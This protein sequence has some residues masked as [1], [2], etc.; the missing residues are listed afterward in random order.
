MRSGQTKPAR[1][2]EE[3]RQEPQNQ[4]RARAWNAIEGE[5]K[6]IEH[7]EGAPLESSTVK[8][9]IGATVVGEVRRR[10]SL[11][12][13]PNPTQLR[14]YFIGNFLPFLAFG[15]FD[16]TIMLICGE[17]LHRH[18]GAVLGISAMAGAAL[19][20]IVGDVCGIGLAGTVEFFSGKTVEDHPLTTRQMKLAPVQRV[21]TSAMA[22]GVFTGCVLGMFPLFFF[23]DKKGTNATAG[24]APTTGTGAQASS[25]PNGALGEGNSGGIATEKD[26]HEQKAVFLGKG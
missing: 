21:K 14:L 1:I 10:G 16:N 13:P 23:E 5:L 25:D 24:V 6:K 11:P 4:K 17:F 8:P 3:I 12:T 20:N 15:F 22:A 26:Q 2:V 18:L 7:A 9:D 19:G